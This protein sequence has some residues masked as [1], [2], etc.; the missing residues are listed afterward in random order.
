M[1]K[2]LNYFTI[3]KKLY[4][5]FAL[6][7]VVLIGVS[8]AGLQGVSGTERRVGVVVE[9]IQPAVLAAMD[10][11]AQ[12]LRTNA[13]MGFFLKT[14]ETADREAYTRENAAMNERVAV[15]N[16]RL[17]ALGDEQF[18]QESAGIAQLVTQLA[19]Y[20]PRLLEL[21]AS[22]LAN[23]PA[24]RR[25][26]E[27]LNPQNQII[28]Q[29]MSEMLGSEVETEEELAG[30]LA[31]YRP[32][33]RWNDDGVPVVDL[34][35]SPIAA[36]QGRFPVLNGVHRLRYT[37][38]QV[39]IGLRGFLAYRDMSFVDSVKQYLE[40][41]DKLASTLGEHSEV[42]TFEQADAYERLLAARKAYGEVL[43]EVVTLHSGERA[44]EDVYLVRSQIGPLDATLS[45]KLGGLVQQLRDRTQVESMA[46]AE[47]AS[48][49]KGLVWSL[50]IGGVLLSAALAWLITRSI[51]CKLNR[52]VTAMREIAE[53]DG[54]LNRE[55]QLAGRDEMAQLA[56]AFNSFLG[57][58]RGTMQEVLGTVH[59][60]TAAAGQMQSV[61]TQATQGT[62]MQQQQTE[63]VAGATTE[64]LASAQEVQQMASSGRNAASTAREAASSGQ[65][66]LQSTRDSL[67]KLF[68]D[69]EQASTVINAL[70]KDSESIG[71]V[72][73]V[74]RG[75]AEQTNLLA[76]NAAIEAARAG[77]QGRG[78]AVVA[79]EVRT[80][81]SRTQE[82]TEE[83]HA[84]IERLQTASR[85]AVGVMQTSQEQASDTVAQ[86][87]EA[88]ANLDAIVSQVETIANVTNEIATASDQQSASI[89]E[90]NRN[91]VSISDVAQQTNRGAAELEASSGSI[92][93]VAGRLAGL[94]G[95]FKL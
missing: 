26:S 42:F 59:Q 83:I 2:I 86:A 19:S 57:K 71:G 81:A 32:D 52:A 47:N 84:M 85:Q 13:A 4:A 20:E 82:S 93:D 55:L 24:Q 14:G 11:Q 65:G 22:S 87:D 27:G 17:H 61:S 1:E 76:L 62:G 36:L 38:S 35:D 60:V 80:L 46:M 50:L 15:L 51:G 67:G 45:E 73:D 33:F 79:D 23:S 40:Q 16:E 43:N 44:F 48:S 63:Q 66:A 7:L 3:T 88:R 37:W 75:I 29:A 28:L 5:A 8:L 95:S 72:L 94:V 10:L 64:L 92:Q 18:S 30:E 89:D 74:I 53:G 39:V 21:S 31:D 25:A 77:E 91:I 9:Q 78:F 70:E 56:E 12:V 6:I 58:I 34:T 68:A 49:T 90:I 69:V 54:D 41:F